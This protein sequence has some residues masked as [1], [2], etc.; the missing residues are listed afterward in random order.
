MITRRSLIGQT[1][2]TVAAAIA[3]PRLAAS[4][5]ARVLKFVPQADLALLDP[6]QS[7]GLVIRHHALLVFDTL[8]GV[9]EQLR[10][11]PQMAQGHV[12]ENGGLVWRISLRD[13]LR[14]HDGER[15]LARDC[16]ASIKRW[17][18][19]DT[20]GLSLMAVV[21]EI[22]APSD[23][24]IRFRLKRPFPLLADVLGKPGTNVCVM[25]PERLAQ[26]DPMQ[27]VTEMVGSG[28]FRYLANERVPGSLNTYEKFS[29]YVPRPGGEPS[30]MAGPKVVH[31]DRVEWR[32]IPDAATAA[33]A[34]QTGEIDWWEQ[35]ISDLIPTLKANRSLKVEVLDRFGAVAMI[36]FNHLQ[37]PFDRPEM[38]RALLAAIK[39]EDYMI[40]VA[41][42]DR[43]YWA[44]S[45]GFFAPGSPMANSAGME[46]LPKTPDIG[47][48][49]EA[50]KAA[51]YAGERI[52]MPVPTDFPA[53]NAMSEVSG[54][55]LR[56]AGINLDYQA[57]DWGTVLQR[58]ASQQPIDKG[59]W[60][61][62][63][64]YSTGVSA[65]NP[66]AHTYLRGVGRTGTFG[67]PTSLELEQMRSDW[68]SAPDEGA[69]LDISKRMQVQAFQDLPYIPLGVFYQPTAYR[70]NLTGVLKGFPLFY[71]VRRG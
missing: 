54:D 59:G 32:T 20:Y 57:L 64:N 26:T 8:Y 56:R 17:G 61:I 66:A 25:M 13:G 39:Q 62:W 42:E 2:A 6:I 30:F 71:N 22:T 36:R 16:V 28:P 52:V 48:V 38:R 69:R 44:D 14:F 7:T 19:R 9:D 29:G 4:Q 55:M 60:N 11:Q 58:V 33:A 68:F 47:R 40:A 53:L 50:L 35:P 51:G 15:V 12:V 31:F 18:A 3:A 70:N 23:T 1:A 21:D 24:E 37:P 67:W 63:C 34:L 65:V 45:V 27:R 46:A 10:P 5:S 49:R 43:S 41:G